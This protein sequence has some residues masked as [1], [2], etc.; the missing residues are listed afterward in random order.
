VDSFGVMRLRL[1]A[2]LVERAKPVQLKVLGSAAGLRRRF[3]L[4]ED[5]L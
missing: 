4:F 5:R 1:P 2:D 3:L